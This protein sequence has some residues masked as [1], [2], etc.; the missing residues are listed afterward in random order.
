M[1]LDVLRS[2]LNIILVLYLVGF[3]I[4]ALLAYALGRNHPD[5]SLLVTVT[6]I[7]IAIGLYVYA[8]TFELPKPGSHGKAWMAIF[9]IASE[10]FAL[11]IALLIGSIRAY[12]KRT[13]ALSH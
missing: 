1:N 11:S 6:L 12:T 4:W 5:S 13:E 3:P 9:L 7:I 10:T 8:I 2:V